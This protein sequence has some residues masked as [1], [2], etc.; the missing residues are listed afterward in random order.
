MAR[1]SPADAAP[2][3][4]GGSS[5]STLP[6]SLTV[7]RTTRALP[8][9]AVAPAMPLLWVL[10]DVL[11]L[12][13]T[14]YGCDNGVCGACTVLLDGRAVRA[15]QVPLSTVGAQAVTTLEGAADHAALRA[16]QLAWAQH[17][18][19][20]CGYCDSGVLLAAAALLARNPRPSVA[21]IEAALT[22]LCPCG[23]TPRFL[24][25]VQAAARQLQPAAPTAPRP[26]RG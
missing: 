21:E 20:Q 18:V 7:N 19:S 1:P 24:P 9:E 17:H 4:S 12:T 8:A 22:H 13:A 23:A 10:R 15:C 26:P 25:A 14:K 2:R 16:L 6:T 3:A 11:G 5:G